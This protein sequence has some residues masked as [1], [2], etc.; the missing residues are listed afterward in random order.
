MFLNSIKVRWA[1]GLGSIFQTCSFFWISQ[2]FRTNMCSIEQ[3][4]GSGFWKHSVCH[5]PLQKHRVESCY[6][7]EAEG[8]LHAFMNLSTIKLAYHFYQ[9]LCEHTMIKSMQHINKTKQATLHITFWSGK[10]R[11]EVHL[12]KSTM[13]KSWFLRAK[14]EAPSCRSWVASVNMFCQR[15]SRLATGAT[16]RPSAAQ[17]LRPVT[18]SHVRRPR[19]LMPPCEHAPL[20]PRG[21]HFLIFLD[22]ENNIHALT[23]LTSLMP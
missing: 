11:C 22:C 14:Q 10:Q 6:Y 1:A 21:I 20:Q 5:W 3:H 16:H 17:T 12:R 13:V 2:V 7:A 8:K 19:T 15:W 18:H 4:I 9:P 23:M